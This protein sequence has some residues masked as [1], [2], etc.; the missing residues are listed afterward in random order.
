[1]IN[2]CFY[3]QFLK[4]Y[5]PF[6]MDVY[7]IKFNSLSW[8]IYF[9]YVELNFQLDS[10]IINT[11]FIF[12]LII[13]NFIILE[14]RIFALIFFEITSDAILVQTIIH[15]FDFILIAKKSLSV[16]RVFH[17]FFIQSLITWGGISLSMLEY[18]VQQIFFQ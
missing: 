8:R 18:Y 15:N 2:F 16:I 14:W 13:S 3:L 6:W 1:M 11:L 17:Q 7:Y 12:R 9:F 4:F 10:W 5:L